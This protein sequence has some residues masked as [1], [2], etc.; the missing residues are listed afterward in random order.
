MCNNTAS[1]R[2]CQM[3]L[4][5]T[6]W[7]NKVFILMRLE[8]KVRDPYY[9]TALCTLDTLSLGTCTRFTSL[10]GII[11]RRKNTLE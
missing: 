10:G 2:E 7:R 8:K 6:Q 4:D 3:M 11:N 5:C 9:L 1:G